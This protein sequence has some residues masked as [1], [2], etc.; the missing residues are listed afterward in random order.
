MV[1]FKAKKTIITSNYLN[2]NIIIKSIFI[3]NICLEWNDG[4]LS[5]IQRTWS[6]LELMVKVHLSLIEAMRA[7]VINVFPM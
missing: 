4:F 6:G 3:G 2:A 1:N 5:K 7:S